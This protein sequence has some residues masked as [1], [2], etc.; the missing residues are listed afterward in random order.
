MSTDHVALLN[1]IENVISSC[2]TMR[3][4]VKFFFF[5]LIRDRLHNVFLEKYINI[6][7]HSA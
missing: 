1:S 5:K 6:D 7:M 4:Y 2:V 3:H